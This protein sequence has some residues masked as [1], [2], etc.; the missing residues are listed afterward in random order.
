[1]VFNLSKVRT[2]HTNVVC[3]SENSNLT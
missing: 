1:M 3:S 2:Q